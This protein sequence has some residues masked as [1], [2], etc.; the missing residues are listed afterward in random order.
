LESSDEAPQGPHAPTTAPDVAVLLEQLRA[1]VEER[2]RAGAYPPGLEHDLDVHFRHI[3]E[4][5]PVRDLDSLHKA[6]AAFEE[7]LTFDT[8]QIPTG[9]RAP[10]GELLHRTVSK[11]IVRQTGW[12]AQ[13][14]QDFAESVRSILW[15]MV[16]TLDNPNHVHGELTAQMDTVLDRLAYYDRAPADAAMLGSILMRLEALEA[17]A[18][19]HSGPTGE[20]SVAARL[21]GRSPV[22][23]IEAGAMQALAATGPGVLDGLGLN[24]DI[25]GFSPG[26]L[27]ELAGLAFERLHPGGLMVADLE[28]AAQPADLVDALRNAGFADVAVEGQQAETLPGRGRPVESRLVHGEPV[29]AKP[30]AA[31]HR[32]RCMIIATR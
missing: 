28:T 17:K 3:V 9:S 1:R 16:E 10:G 27:R 18:A 2:R 25:S 20:R 24:G 6:M 26:Q 12:L 14:L 15:K 29:Q 8:A 13:Q 21:A 31:P 22:L 32:R 4:H 19:G 11:V 7:R 30:A 5:R 23:T